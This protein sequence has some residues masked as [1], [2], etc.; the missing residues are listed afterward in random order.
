MPN[1]ELIERAFGP[2]R[3][4]AYDDQFLPL[5][6]I[7]DALNLIL[8]ARLGRLPGDASLLVAGAGTGAEVRFL[9]P[10]FPGWRFTL[11][12][13]AP[14]MLDIAREHAAAE[15]FA[16]RCTFHAG[17][18]DTAPRDRHHA[19][20]SVLVS[21]FLTDSAERQAYFRQLADRLLPGGV[22]FEA[23]LAADRDT[24]SFDTLVE[25][26]LDLLA[27]AGPVDRDA[28]RGHVGKMVAA[29]GPDE[30]EALL[31]AAGFEHPTRCFQHAMIHGWVATR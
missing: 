23:G 7:K 14:A 2:D 15:G 8:R 9:A 13:P 11:V 10:L 26:W 3:A 30:V 25:L 16:D 24:P 21:H 19:A 6:A 29:H 28:Y 31:V 4:P 17:Y 1:P 22:L 18:L 20:L 12:D 27:L 5:R